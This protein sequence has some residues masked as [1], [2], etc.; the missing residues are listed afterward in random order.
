MQTSELKSGQDVVDFL[1]SQHEQIKA[2][3]AEVSHSNGNAKQEAFD[4]LRRL[5]AVHETAEEQVVHPRV[6]RIVDDVE[7]IVDDRL[8]E[9]HDAKEVLSELEKLDITSDEFDAKFATFREDVVAHAEAEEREEFS[10]LSEALDQ[11]E[12]RSL[13]RAAELTERM[14]P[15]HPHAGVES[16][17]ANLLAGPFAAMLDRARDVITGHAHDA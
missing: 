16:A 15:T 6:K 1:T 5:L 7:H 14:A 4:R 10:R 11:Q 2:L 9:E 8:R 12:L 3:F 17:T 13:G